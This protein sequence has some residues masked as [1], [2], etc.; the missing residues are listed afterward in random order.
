MN[1]LQVQFDKEYP[2]YTL[3]PRNVIQTYDCTIY[4]L[5]ELN[6]YYCAVIFKSFSFEQKLETEHDLVFMTIDDDTMDLL[7]LNI[8]QHAQN[9][10]VITHFCYTSALEDMAYFYTPTRGIFAK[11]HNMDEV[12]ILSPEQINIIDD[13]TS[14]VEYKID[15]SICKPKTGYYHLS[16]S[17]PSKKSRT[18]HITLK[19]DSK[20]NSN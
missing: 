7:N 17:D 20:F 6:K 1:K 2:S 14:V 8:I 11:K 15:Y 3:K 16:F 5:S 13:M 12:H 9:Q 18:K 4:E 10:E 19:L